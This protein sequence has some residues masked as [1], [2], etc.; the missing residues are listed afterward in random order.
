MDTLSERL[1]QTRVLRRLP[2]PAMRQ[3]IRQQA[4]LSQKDIARALGCT[5]EAVALREAG[6]R[7]PR[8][9]VAAKYLAL[10]GRLVAESMRE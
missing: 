8:P 10:L 9:A 4:E 6:K 7:T 2:A 1:E 3:Q 5:R